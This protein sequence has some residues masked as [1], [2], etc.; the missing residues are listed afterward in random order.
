MD[1]IG[2]V[3]L[4]HTHALL[5]PAVPHKQY[6]RRR[7]DRSS[8]VS[9]SA[10]DMPARS[11]GAQ[12]RGPPIGALLRSVQIMVD[13][14]M[15]RRAM[16]SRPRRD[17]LGGTVSSHVGRGID[18]QL[19]AQLRQRCRRATSAPSRRRD[20]HPPNRHP[21]RPRRIDAQRA[22]LRKHPSCRAAQSSTAAGK[23]CRVPCGNR[24]KPRTQ[25]A[26]L[27]KWRQARHASRDR[28]AA[29]RRRGNRPSPAALRS[30]FVPAGR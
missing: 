5:A 26:A 3:Q 16:S 18:Q 13:E 14:P 11:G 30:A 10:G 6:P 28:P 15:H 21:P 20:C 12:R 25:R 7:A 24:P 17:A 8:Q 9:T 27:A 19:E 29:S 22:R 2:E 23:M 4:R 1:L